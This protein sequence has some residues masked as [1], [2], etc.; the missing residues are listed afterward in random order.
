MSIAQLKSNNP[1]FSFIISKNP[2]SFMQGKNIRKGKAF[3]WFSNENKAYNMFFSDY[4]DEISFKEHMN[5]EFEYLNISK[6]N[7]A[8]CILSLIDEFLNSALKKESYKDING[9]VCYEKSGEYESSFYILRIRIKKDRLLEDFN[10]HF[11]GYKLEYKKLIGDDFELKFTTKKTIYELVNMVALFC[12]FVFLSNKKEKRQNDDFA[13]KYLKCLQVVDAPYFIRQIFKLNVIKSNKYFYDNKELLEKSNRYKIDFE[14]GD[15]WLMRKNCIEKNLDFSRDIVDLGCH[16]GRYITSFAKKNLDKFYH[17]I[18]IDHEVLEKAKRRT[19]DRSI[20]N[21]L[22]YNSWEDF[23]SKNNGDSN[24]DLICTEVVEH[25]EENE[26]INLIRNILEH[27]G[28]NSCI[29]TTPCSEFNK[30]YFD[31][32]SYRHD[33]HKWEKTREEFKVWVDK[34]IKDKNNFNIEF[35]SIGDKVD[36]I[37]ISQGVKFF[38]VK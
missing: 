5:Q 11:P 9:N 10:F 20:E 25:I 7:S 34:I 36:G 14:E 38:K 35:L 23:S 4:P 17:A 1:N 32:D 33:D 19:K 2:N 13:S 37:P 29:I 8:E 16:S 31:D 30:F 21:V 15:S 3:G 6:F 12:V 22:F 27:P 26:A 28:L 24:F 18:D